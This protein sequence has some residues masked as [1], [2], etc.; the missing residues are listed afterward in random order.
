MTGAAGTVNQSGTLEVQ[1]AGAGRDTVFGRIVEAVERAE[2]S[3]APVQKTADR[4]AGYLVYFALG[5]AALTFLITRD[6]RST[7]SVVIVAGACGI[8]AGTQLAWRALVVGRP[9]HDR[10]FAA[11]GRGGCGHRLGNLLLVGVFVAHAGLHRV[12]VLGHRML[13]ERRWN[14]QQ[15]RNERHCNKALAHRDLRRI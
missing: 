1:A 15:H 5:A 14:Q 7:I 3:R 11:Y 8:A 9:V 2:R 12:L 6:A 10:G 4:L 13:G